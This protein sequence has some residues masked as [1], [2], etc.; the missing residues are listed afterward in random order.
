M[1]TIIPPG[2]AVDW[3]A[4]EGTL[5]V[6]G[7]APWATIEFLRAFYT[8]IPA[9]KDWH[10]P[11]VITDTNTKL[12]SRGRHLQL[13]ER[14]PSPFI[15]ETIEEMAAL[16]AT[17]IVLPCNTA[18]ILYDRWASAS[19]VPVPHIVQETVYRA[20]L[21]GARLVTAFSSTSLASSDLYGSFIEKSGMFCY[22]LEASDQALISA[23]LEEVKVRGA[24]GALNLE[25]LRLLC[26]TLRRAEVDTVLLGCTELSGIAPHLQAAGLAVFDSN[27]ALA[28]SALALVNGTSSL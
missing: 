28:E 14:D 9:S 19:P 11:R 27:L 26:E 13:G 25:H 24:V 6:I 5:G 10:Y 15:A 7:V 1:P 12:P 4:Q 20:A 16:G 22:R 18:H 8:L 17:V 3:P 23:M 21:N 2:G